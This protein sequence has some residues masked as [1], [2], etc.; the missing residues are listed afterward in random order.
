MSAEV[1]F[2]A[3]RVDGGEPTVSCEGSDEIAFEQIAKN[4]IRLAEEPLECVE[5]ARRLGHATVAQQRHD[6]GAK[7]GEEV[8]V[9]WR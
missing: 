7:S 5:E 1:R 2:D 8:M 3:S 4:R 9:R 6:V